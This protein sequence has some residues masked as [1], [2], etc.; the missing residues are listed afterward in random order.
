MYYKDNKAYKNMVRN[1]FDIG[2]FR[3]QMFHSLSTSLKK[4][5]DSGIFVTF[6]HYHVVIKKHW[7]LNVSVNSHVLEQ[8]Q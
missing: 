1:H 7:K 5:H 8:I 6:V 2:L 3:L 4:N